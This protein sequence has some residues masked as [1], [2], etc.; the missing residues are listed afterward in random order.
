MPSEQEYRAA[1]ELL[2]QQEKILAEQ[3]KRQD[4]EILR[5]KRIRRR[6]IVLRSVSLFSGVVVM[7]FGFI[8][9]IVIQAMDANF[10]NILIFTLSEIIAIPLLR[11]GVVLF[12]KMPIE[13]E[14]TAAVEQLIQVQDGLS[15]IRNERL[16][17][18]RNP[19]KSVRPHATFDPGKET[20]RNED[21][22]TF[23][24]PSGVCPECG[25]KIRDGAK[26][27]RQCGHLFL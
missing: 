2:D 16:A 4:R 27:C 7:L 12:R 21:L 17:L 15:H 11:F 23:D 25:E 18:M 5:L 14:M 20:K 19:V 22:V 9:L 3:V 24:E 13:R 1:E 10:N 6:R 8:D 26:I